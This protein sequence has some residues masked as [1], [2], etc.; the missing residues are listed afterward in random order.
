LNGVRW[1]ADECVSPSLVA[2]LRDAGE[3]VAYM[4]EIARG[5]DDDDVAV[6]AREEERLLLTEDRDFGDRVFRRDEWLPGIVFLRIEGD[7]RLKWPRL[8]AAI[9][10]FGCC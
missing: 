4:L 7:R 1:L 5:A 9:D 10:Q 6:R 2:R 8:Q 3:D